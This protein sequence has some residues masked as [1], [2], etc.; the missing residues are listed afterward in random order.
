[1]SKLFNNVLSGSLIVL[2][3]LPVIAL[4]TAHAATLIF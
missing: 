1:M 2:G 4:S 3:A